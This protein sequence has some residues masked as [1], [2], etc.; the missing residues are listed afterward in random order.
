MVVVVDGAL[1]VRHARGGG[2]R[3]WCGGGRDGRLGA[4]GR[5]RP[6]GRGARVRAG[7]RP[8]PRSSRA[9]RSCTAGSAGTP[10]AGWHR[11]GDASAE[12]VP[13]LSSGR[14]P[15]VQRATPLSTDADQP[16][17]GSA[18][19]SF[20]PGGDLEGDVDG[21]RA[22]AAVLD[23]RSRWSCGR[24]PVICGGSGWMWAPRRPPPRA[25]DAGRQCRARRRAGGSGVGG[26]RS[27]GTVLLR[28]DG[29]FGDGLFLVEL[30]H[31]ADDGDAPAG[32]GSRGRHRRTASGRGR[33]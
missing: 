17:S 25:S 8:S 26:V 3:G 13:E 31:P 6:P 22:L 16:G 14:E 4:C 10:A 29:D 28:V 24:R 32:P 23:R 20:T 9:G 15:P 30:G 1:V 5:P 19:T 12:N 21:R 2:G 11:W 27:W 7:P 18:T 33:P